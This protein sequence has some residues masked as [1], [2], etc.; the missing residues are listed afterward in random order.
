MANNDIRTTRGERFSYS[1]SA[2]MAWLVYRRF[3]RDLVSATRAW[4]RMLQ[5]NCNETQF[6]ELVQYSQLNDED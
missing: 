5:N 1:D 4:N 2:D 6:Q 3:G